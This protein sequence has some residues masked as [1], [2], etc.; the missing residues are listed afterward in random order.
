MASQLPE[1]HIRHCM[2]FG[3]RKGNTATEATKNI[4]D[5]YPSAL[6]VRKCQRWFS[7]FR[8][9][10]FDVTD[11]HRS[12]RLTTL[13]NDELRAGVEANPCQIIEELSNSLNQPSKNICRRLENK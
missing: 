11:S 5:I 9:G 10:N 4:C 12:G 6:D 1:E 7:K 3:F 8:S 13:D 2:L